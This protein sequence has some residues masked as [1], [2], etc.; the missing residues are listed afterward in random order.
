[1]KQYLFVLLIVFSV[2]GLKSQS[3]P[4]SSIPDSLKEN[5]DM[6]VRLDEMVVEIKSPGRMVT[7]EHHVYTILN[8]N[9]DRY[10]TYRTGYDKFTSINYVNAVLFDAAGKE[11]KHFRKKDMEDHPVEDGESLVNDRRYK[12]GSLGHYSYPYTVDFEEED[13]VNGIIGMQ[14]W[15]LWRSTK[16][17][18]QISR[19]VIVSPKDY[20]VRYRLV[21][22]DFPP[23]ISEKNNKITYSWEMGNLPTIPDEPFAVPPTAYEPFMLVGPSELEIEGYKGNFSTWDDYGKFY[24]ALQKGRDV[25]PDETKAKVHALTDG[26]PDPG[27]KV[28]V[29]YDYLQKNTHYVG[30]QLGIGGWQ[31]FD[32]AYVANRKY[33]DCKALSNFMI[34]LLK[35]AGI[36]AYAV[37]IHGGERNADFIRDFTYDPFN[38]VI[39]CVPLKKDTVWLECTSQSLPAGYLG[40]WTSDRYGLLI[41]DNG[42]VLVHTPAYLLPGNLQERKLVAELGT[43][44]S[45]KVQCK[46]GY[47]AACQDQIEYII[48]H[49]SKEDQLS[50]LK[51]QFDLPTYD[52]SSYTYQKDYSHPLPV[53]RESL[54]LTVN[55]YAQVSNKRIFVNPNILTRSRVKLMEDKNRRLDIEFND[56]YCHIDSVRITIPSG[57]DT[58]SMPKDTSLES[59]FGRYET[60]MVVGPDQIIYY[61]KFEQYSGRFSRTDYGEL[62]KFYNEIYESDRSKIVLVKKS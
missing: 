29:L 6:V 14:G 15:S 2:S 11:L 36:K 42:G 49:W 20:K 43:D 35:E 60:R 13:E 5:A 61:R 53:V 34:S 33:G 22:A 17:S 32:A 3:Y 44:G 9:A 1:M 45:L 26:I 10:A 8:E 54:Q 28:S 55:D 31:T 4:A 21:H 18:L 57:Y 24:G 41:E 47:K 58:E 51:S 16:A 40:D 50:R 19:Y 23:S 46:T 7:R 59:K 30:I 25:L 56:E 38:H 62:V 37:I 48:D 39:C 27:K 52:L 12:I